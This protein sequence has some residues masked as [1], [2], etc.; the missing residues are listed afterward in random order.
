VYIDLFIFNRRHVYNC[1]TYNDASVM[2][3]VNRSAAC[4]I[5]RSSCLISFVELNI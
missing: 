1:R 4:Y 5:P 2:K 3:L